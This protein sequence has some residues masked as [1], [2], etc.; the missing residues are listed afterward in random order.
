MSITQSF[1]YSFKAELL[2]GVHNLDTA[3]NTV[4]AA[5]FVATVA[6][7][8]GGATT[9]YSS[10]GSDELATAGG[11]TAGGKA[12]T[13]TGVTNSGGVGFVSF[14]NVSWTSATFTSSG[15]LLYNSTQSGKALVVLSFGQPISVTAGTFTMQFPNNDSNNAVIRIT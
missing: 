15:S 9:N 6:G 2:Q 5:L 11:Y 1:C 3:G 12:L 14:S 4:K 8:Y 7:T 10:M 13:S